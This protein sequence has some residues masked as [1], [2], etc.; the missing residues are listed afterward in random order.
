[1]LYSHHGKQFTN[2]PLHLSQ[3]KNKEI[4]DISSRS[5]ETR[6]GIARD[7]EMD[8]IRITEGSYH[9]IF[10]GMQEKGSKEFLK[11]LGSKEKNGERNAAEQMKEPAKL[12]NTHRRAKIEY[13]TRKGGER[14]T[15]SLRRAAIHQPDKGRPHQVLKCKRHCNEGL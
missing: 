4:G 1:M 6:G 12:K 13:Y 11:K 9:V 14:K 5:K 2:P 10:D 8:L 7:Q 15:N 3:K